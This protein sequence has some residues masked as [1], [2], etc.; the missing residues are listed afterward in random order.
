[1]AQVSLPG[2]GARG[3]EQSTAWS[4]GLRGG[5]MYRRRASLIGAVYSSDFCFVSIRLYRV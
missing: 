4:H 3:L 1:M 5:C 2:C